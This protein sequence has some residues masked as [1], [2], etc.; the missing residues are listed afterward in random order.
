VGRRRGH[1]EIVGG[2]QLSAPAQGG[3]HLFNP[4][5]QIG[6]SRAAGWQ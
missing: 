3:E 2:N 6:G 4:G 1:G 5:R